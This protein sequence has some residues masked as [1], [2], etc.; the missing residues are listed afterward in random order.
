MKPFTPNRLAAACLFWTNGISEVEKG[1]GGWLV[2]VNGTT[3]S[4]LIMCELVNGWAKYAI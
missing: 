3:T 2:C 4:L 1:E